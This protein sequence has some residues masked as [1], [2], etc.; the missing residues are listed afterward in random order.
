MNLRAMVFGPAYLDRVLRVDRP[1]VDPALGPPLDQ[2]VEGR[3]RFAGGR[4][5]E[6]ADPS[7]YTI[8]I[9]LPAGWPGPFGRIEL[10]AGDPRGGNWPAGCQRAELERRP[11]RHGGRLCRRPGRER[12]AAH[13]GPRTTRP[14]GGRGTAGPAGDRALRDPGRRPSGRL[15]PARDQRRAWR[16]AADRLSRLSCGARSRLVRPLARLACDLRVVAG[17]AQPAGGPYPVR[18]GARCRA[19]R[20]GDA[21]HARS[22]VSP[23]SSFAGS[24]DLLCCNRQEW[25]TLDDREEVAW[26]VSILVVTDGPA[27]SLARFTT[28]HGRSGHGPRAGVPSRPSAARHQPGRRGLRGDLHVHPALPRLAARVGRRRRGPGPTGHDPGL[29]RRRPGPRPHRF[30]LSRTRGCRVRPPRRQSHMKPE[31][32]HHADRI[33]SDSTHRNRVRSPARNRISCIR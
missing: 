13:S 5:L 7:G 19:V 27:G 21:E 24:I 29:G 26:R 15:D 20:P 9:E 1:L 32:L 16:Q 31:I 4:N 33:A 18:P 8:E 12:S 17:A 14:A 10:A 11:G 28:P 30:R 25:E 23:V 22:R 3:W 6:L 2:S